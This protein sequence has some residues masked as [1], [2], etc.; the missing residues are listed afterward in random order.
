MIIKDVLFRGGCALDRLMYGTKF[1]TLIN[2]NNKG[3]DNNS[4]GDS[5][6]AWDF[7]NEDSKG[8]AFDELTDS[9]S[10]TGA[11]FNKMVATIAISVVAS[12][13]I[14]CGMEFAAYKNGGKKQ[15]LKEHLPYLILGVVF[16][17][18][19][20]IVFTLGESIVQGIS[21]SL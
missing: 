5:G 7:L 1:G 8:G 3:D 19:F 17:I 15:E 18:G 16:V 4:K 21:D 20:T 6:K 11:S 10:K 13:I 12:A 2:P 14:V 9:V